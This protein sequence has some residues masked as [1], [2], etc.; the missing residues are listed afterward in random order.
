MAG[1]FVVAIAATIRVCLDGEIGRRSGLKIRRPQ[2][3]P[4]RVRLEARF[5]DG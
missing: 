5:K 4:V 2:A 1:F 3:V